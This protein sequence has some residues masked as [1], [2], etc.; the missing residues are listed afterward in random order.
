MK[1]KAQQSA[2]RARIVLGDRGRPGQRGV[3]EG[4]GRDGRAQ[5]LHGGFHMSNGVLGHEDRQSG[6]QVR[7]GVR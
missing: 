1:V 6:E 2:G 4:R 3:N 5:G 7:V